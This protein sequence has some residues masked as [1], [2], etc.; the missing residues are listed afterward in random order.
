MEDV[1]VVG[2]AFRSKGLSSTSLSPFIISQLDVYLLVVS[3][4][5]C[6]TSV[7]TYVGSEVDLE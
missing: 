3:C 4:T 2:G 1:G 5:V 6:S 7:S